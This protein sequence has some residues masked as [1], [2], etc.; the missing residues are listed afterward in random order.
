MKLTRQKNKILII[1]IVFAI[2]IFVF[3]QPKQLFNSPA[4][5]VITDVSGNLLG[6]RIATDGQWR[7]PLND[8][9]PYKF[10]QAIITFEDKYFYYHFGINP[11]S[12]IRALAQNIKARH[13]VSGGSTITAQVIRLS[14]KGKQRTVWQKIVEY[15]FAVRLELTHSKNEILA[16]YASNAPFG[17][18]V[19]G[20]DAAAWRY[21]GRSPDKLS[22]GEAASLAVLPNAPSII[23]PGKNHQKY[24]NKR[25]RLLDKLRNRK[26]IDS[27][28]CELAKSEP[29]P[30]KP[31]PLPNLAPHL[32]NKAIND[33]YE[34]KV[35]KT[36]VSECFQEIVLQVINKHHKILSQNGINNAAAIVVD[37]ETG[38]ILAYVGNATSN[39]PDAGQNV[40]IIVSQRS[41]GSTLKPVLYALMQKYG[42][43]LPAA[44][45]PD[46][47]TTIA[48]YSPQNFSKSFDGAVHANQALARSLNIPAVRMLK[49]FG[50]ERFREYLQELNFTTITKPADY[51]G[52]SVILGGAEITMWDIAG[53]YASMAR[54]LNHY[55]G[56]SSRYFKNDYHSLYYIEHKTSRRQESP[57]D[58]FGAGAIW[59][60]FNAL[61]EMQR[62]GLAGDWH[63]FSSNKKI[64]WK[65]GTSFGYRDAW[66]IG[67][68]PKYVVVAWAGNADGEGRAGLTGAR[69]AAPVM[70]DI[71]KKLPDTKWFD[72]PY[73]DLVEMVV[74]KQSGYKASQICTDTDTIL[75]TKNGELTQIC[76]YHKI[77][78]L[79]KTKKYRVNSHCYPVSQ[80]V[81][82]SR[83]VLPPVMEWYYK[84]KNLFYEPLPP[85]MSG[86]SNSNVKNMDLIYPVP[87]MRFFIPKGFTGKKQRVILKAA[88]RMPDAVIY[89]HLDDKYIGKTKGVH[90]MEVIAPP[91]RHTIT[92]VD[93]YGERLSQSFEI[94]ES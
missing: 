46:I 62:P 54:V 63:I 30:Q 34:G 55:T 1:T 38:N 75:T 9:V 8:T 36:T 11:F 33:G 12:I 84:N 60:T 44:I 29:L 92:I 72:T 39:I 49:M 6:A 73:D 81:K 57:D 48:G 52:L 64:A 41:S 10:K 56:N 91:G 45:I 28:T 23:F 47:P 86:C 17:G 85:I 4:S 2:V 87:N 43:I 18:N 37:V 79:D 40:D 59:L 80:M 88:H 20:L 69:A 35:V 19:V 93:Q 82:E 78:F 89:W 65:T 3:S 14:R 15:I 67:V 70:F 71:F 74:C 76:P 16:L 94:V 32:L 5:T 22:W 68:T 31:Q 50:V 61:T 7:F 24:L 90:K 21:F 13:V 83:F 53:V 42:T 77:I 26:I 66:A 51:Y 25:N 27:T 58:I